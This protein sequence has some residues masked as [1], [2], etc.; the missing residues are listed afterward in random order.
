[1]AAFSHQN[2]LDV[3]LQLRLCLF[4]HSGLALNPFALLRDEVN[5][6]THPTYEAKKQ[7]NQYKVYSVK[8]KVKPGYSGSSGVCKKKEEPV[9]ILP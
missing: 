4:C 7:R 3:G 2:I 6:E 1:M 5:L 9:K 8:Y